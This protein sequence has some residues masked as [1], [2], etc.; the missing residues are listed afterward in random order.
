MNK[1]QVI[2]VDS[3][4]SI[5]NTYLKEDSIQGLCINKDMSISY[6]I[7]DEYGHGTAIYGIIRDV[8]DAANILNIK[9]PEIQNGIEACNLVAILKYIYDNFTPDVI[10]LSM[11]ISIC[12]DYKALYNICKKLSDRGTIIVAAFDNTGCYSYPAIF[13]CVVGVISH[14][15]CS[16]HKKYIYFSDNIVN[17]AANGNIQR[18]IWT[19]P[20]MIFMGGNSFACAHMTCIIVR[21][22]QNSTSKDIWSTLK[23]KADLKCKFKKN[24]HKQSQKIPFKI[25]KAALFPF[26]KEMHSLIRFSQLLDFDIVDIYDVKYSLKVHAS[27][28]VLLKENLTNNY[29][30]KDINNIK[31]ENIDTLIIGHLKQLE[32]LCNNK[33][34]FNDLLEKARQNNIQII[35][36][37][38][39]EKNIHRNQKIYYPVVNNTF[40]DADRFGMMYRIFKPV[41]SIL[42]TSSMQGK[43]TLQLKLRELFLKNGVNL[44]QIGTEPTALLFNMD[45][46]YPMGYGNSV[47]LNERDAI[48]YL[49]SII[50]QLCIDGKDII[51][52]GSQ[53][54]TIP[55]DVGNLQMFTSQ[56][57]TFL[58]GTQPDATILC[59]NPYD[60]SNYI[61]KTISAIKSL[62]DSDIIALVVYPLTLKNFDTGAYGGKEVLANESYVK[63]K[64]EFQN[65]FALPVFKL[66]DNLDMEMLFDVICSY[67]Q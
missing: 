2:I 66:G 59:V 67:F 63:I 13:D 12:D 16:N 9:I 34:L 39:V 10:N 17:F 51:V 33:N 56:Q 1:K 3:G 62:T 38:E 65:K 61:E 32:I 42:G 22:L 19:E 4:V 18:L 40:L 36:F 44:G 8:R 30:I 41:L 49:N 50:Y 54:N 45:Y 57:L 21:V 46:A 14:V 25:N 52:T 64:K 23:Q 20:E 43:F 29:I 15:E 28:N 5:N 6:D 37:D 53:S 26:S 31:W 58:L 55:Y 35:S 24:K 11:G 47:H 7:N 27:T 48:M 60:D